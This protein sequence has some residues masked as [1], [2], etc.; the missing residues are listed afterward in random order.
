M[1]TMQKPPTEAILA[2]HEQLVKTLPMHDEQD[3]EDARR[4]YLGTIEPAVVRGAR[5]EVVWDAGSYAFLD[6]D[7]PA[8]V[9]PSLWR[10]STLTAMHGLFEVVPGI[11]QVRGLD[12]SNV[13]FVEGERGVLVIDP[14][15]SAETAA[16]ALRLYRTHRGD[17]PVTGVVYT[18]S[19]VDHFGGVEGVVSPEAVSA[20]RVPILAP[21]GFLEHAV[22]ENV[23]A[24]T[25]MTRRA[26]YMYGASLP[27]GP[28]G[29]VGAG[30]GQTTS[31]GTAGIIAPTVDIMRT[32][33]EEV[34]D[35]I[36]MVFQMAPGSEA[37]AEMHLYLP[38]FRAL[39]MA[40][41]ATHVLHNILTI[42]GA[43]VR[44]PHAWAG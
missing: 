25:A 2:V 3:F 27:R 17:R 5:G 18:H 31:T 29:Q 23:Y 15:I 24:G 43:L 4:G 6:G 32:G 12:L 22:S 44:D 28:Q 11:Y 42:R 39:C 13:S 7:A 14:L 37:S 36:R 8:T 40:E 38:D 19:H 10:Q 34:V 41:N 20:G 21:E 26:G 16:A 1:D 33:Q 30:L 9:N 35:G